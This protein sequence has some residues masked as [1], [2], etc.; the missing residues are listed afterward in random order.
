MRDRLVGQM[1]CVGAEDPPCKRCRN[2]G[3][4]CMFEKPVREGAQVGEE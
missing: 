3:L 2:A 1:R 4:Q